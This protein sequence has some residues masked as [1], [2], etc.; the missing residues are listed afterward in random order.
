M[1]AFGISVQISSEPELADVE[2][3]VVANEAIVADWLR[4][5]GLWYVDVGAPASRRT[6]YRE[7]D[8]HLAAESVT[9]RATPAERLEVIAEYL[10]VPWEWFR[11]RCQE[12]AVAGVDDIAHPRSRLL[13]TRGLNTAIRYVAYID[14]LEGAE[15]ARR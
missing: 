10:N 14:T 5:S 8:D 3:F 7:I 13:S 6:A 9:D 12:L 4:G 2:G 1:E 11:T 15:L